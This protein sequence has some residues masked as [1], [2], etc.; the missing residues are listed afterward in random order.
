MITTSAREAAE[1]RV[2]AV[3]DDPA[4]RLELMARLFDGPTG[5]APRAL[6]FRRAA[7]SFMLWQADR[8]VLDPGGS[9]WWRAMNERLLRDGCEAVARSAGLGG[10]MSSPTIGLWMTFIATPTART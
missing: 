9:P 6:P 7:L 2:A 3:R 8:G 1:A 10:E 5:P 4:G